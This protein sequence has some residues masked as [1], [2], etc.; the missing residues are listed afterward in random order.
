M[1]CKRALTEARGDFDK[2]I[3]CYTRALKADPALYEA[4]LF[5]G[6]VYFKMNKPDEAG[7]WYSAAIRLNPDRE[8]AY[9]YWAD[10]LERGGKMAAARLRLIDA[11][12]A[13]PYSQSC[14]RAARQWA[15]RAGVR[16][17][18]PEIPV[19]DLKQGP[20]GYSLNLEL[21]NAPDTDG[22]LS[23]LAYVNVRGRWTKGSTFQDAYKNEK[24][25]R[26]SLREE[27][28]ALQAVADLA[29]KSLADGKV[30][31]LD[32]GLKILKDLATSKLIEPYVLLTRADRG[33]A[34]DYATYRKEHSDR[35]RE[36][37]SRYV[38]PEVK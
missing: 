7:K 12:V 6:D 24:V 22:S 19:P 3:E 16:I 20:D 10:V 35:L 13:S 21:S 36:Y 15:A 37:L 30:K 33:I 1:D 18:A 17:A 26:H 38:F 2:A 27:T 8:T 31:N 23:W 5:L 14:A 9:Y 25:Y 4:P 34:Q 32:P 28:E 29:A 11:L